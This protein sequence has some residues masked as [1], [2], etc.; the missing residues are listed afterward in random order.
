MTG[1]HEQELKRCQLPGRQVNR[2]I[3]AEECAIGLQ[4]EDSEGES[5]F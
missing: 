4:T 5:R 3:F 1:V 2:L